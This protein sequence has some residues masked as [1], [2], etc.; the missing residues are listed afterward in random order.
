M[1]VGDLCKRPAVSATAA[2]PLVEVAKLMRSRH[3][4]S[5]VVVDPFGSQKPV[6]ILTDRDIVVEVLA[7][8]VDPAGMSAGDIMTAAPVVA[9]RGEDAMWAL[10]MMRDRG[11]RRLPI[12]DDDGALYGVLALDDLMHYIC[13]AVSDVAQLLGTERLEESLRRV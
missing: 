1:K 4:G 6:G 12:V 3:V 13:G 9:S 5:V 11:I 7:T 2:V 10:K 8:G